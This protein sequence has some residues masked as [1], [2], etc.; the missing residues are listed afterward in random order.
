MRWKCESCRK[1]DVSR[2]FGACEG[3]E[4]AVNKYKLIFDMPLRDIIGG[5]D[6]GR[7]PSQAN[8]AGEASRRVWYII[9][10]LYY[11]RRA[12]LCDWLHIRDQKTREDGEDAS[13]SYHV[14]ALDSSMGISLFS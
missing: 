6:P 2:C 8:E 7:F 13:L 10:P 9:A 11:G 14:E 12:I 1:G 4:W 5:A 3:A